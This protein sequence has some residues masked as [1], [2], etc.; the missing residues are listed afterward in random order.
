M[1]TVIPR[2]LLKDAVYPM[3]SLAIGPSSFMKHF[4][5]KQNDRPNQHRNATLQDARRK[6]N[7]AL[8]ELLWELLY[9]TDSEA[10]ESLR[11]LLW[12]TKVAVLICLNQRKQGFGFVLHWFCD[13]VRVSERS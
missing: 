6:E 5:R 2:T 13:D 9:N 12:K 10:G 1:A 3:R 11:A 8:V 4:S 7:G